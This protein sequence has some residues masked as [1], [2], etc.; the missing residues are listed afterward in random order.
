MLHVAAVVVVVVCVSEHVCDESR[1]RSVQPSVAV[2]VLVLLLL[3]LKS[4]WLWS[5]IDSGKNSAAVFVSN[6]SFVI[7]RGPV[8]GQAGVVLSAGG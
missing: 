8:R 7:W 3:L 5:L 4:A 2:L 1:L 6:C